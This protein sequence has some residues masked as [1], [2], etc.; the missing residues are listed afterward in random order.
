[1]LNF[2]LKEIGGY[3][4]NIA[5]NVFFAITTT[6]CWLHDIY[7]MGYNL[8]ISLFTFT[9]I[10]VA[11]TYINLIKLYSNGTLSDLFRFK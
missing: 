2:I 7:Q 9:P 8:T 6:I 11:C 4:R 5:R 10:C 1:M 3:L